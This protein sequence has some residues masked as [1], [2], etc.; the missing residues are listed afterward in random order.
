MRSSSF[1]FQSVQL[2]TLS[3][4]KARRMRFWLNYVRRSRI[5]R[6]ASPMNPS[7]AVCLSHYFL[8]HEYI[9]YWF[10]CVQYLRIHKCCFSLS[11]DYRTIALELLLFY[12]FV[13]AVILGLIRFTCILYNFMRQNILEFYPNFLLKRVF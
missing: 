12:A 9:I 6:V 11:I 13:A 3:L 4:R 1:H 7:Q 5:R 8:V 10:R 2:S